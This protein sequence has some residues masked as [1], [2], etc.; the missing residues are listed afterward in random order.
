M[1][2][3]KKQSHTHFTVQKP[4]KAR[5]L[6]KLVAIFYL[7]FNIFLIVALHWLNFPEVTL[8]TFLLATSYSA[9]LVVTIHFLRWRVEIENTEIHHR[10]LFSEKRFSFH[11]IKRASTVNGV[12]KFYSGEGKRLL[13]IGLN[14]DNADL[15]MDCILDRGIE[16]R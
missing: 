13:S 6:M 2:A 12:I 3:D 15:F 4:P 14:D 1:N 11:D 5:N 10:S 16:V 7:P 8:F 9:L